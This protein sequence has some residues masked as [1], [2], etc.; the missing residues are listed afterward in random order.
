MLAWGVV[1][2]GSA[3]VSLGFLRHPAP[4]HGPASPLSL[5]A[6]IAAR[7]ATDNQLDRSEFCWSFRRNKKTLVS[8]AEA[9]ILLAVPSA[10]RALLLPDKTWTVTVDSEL[11]VLPA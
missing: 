8:G 4:P 11:H 9:L 6:Q 1:Q 2:K 3:G 5:D 10:M 7:L